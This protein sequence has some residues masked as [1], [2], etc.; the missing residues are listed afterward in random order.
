MFIY[1]LC[2]C[3]YAMYVHMYVKVFTPIH[4]QRPEEGTGCTSLSLCFIPLKKA[5]TMNL[6]YAG[7][8]KS[9]E[10]LLSLPK[11]D[12]ARIMVSHDCFFHVVLGI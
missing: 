3:A 7:C 10:R 5:L 6:N 9:P 8:Q 1:T 4:E 12:S 2:V 11:T